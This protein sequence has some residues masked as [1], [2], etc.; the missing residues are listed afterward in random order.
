MGCSMQT[1]GLGLLEGAVRLRGDMAGAGGQ[2]SSTELQQSHGWRVSQPCTRQY[3]HLLGRKEM[4]WHLCSLQ[5]QTAHREQQL[6]LPR[7][8]S[9]SLVCGKPLH[10]FTWYH[11]C[12]GG[13]QDS[14]HKCFCQA[15]SPGPRCPRSL[16]WAHGIVCALSL[17]GMVA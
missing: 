8:C 6:T 9:E 3:L 11:A 14:S 12:H 1:Q 7:R 2:P 13:S 15:C 16:D 10:L 4:S 17:A 5:G